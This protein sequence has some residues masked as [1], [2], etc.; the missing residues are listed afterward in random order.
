MNTKFI[1]VKDFRQNI[2]DYAKRAQKSDTR[3]IVM[4]RNKPLFEI[5]AFAEDEYLDSFVADI[6]KAEADVARG[7]YHTHEEVMKVL[8]IA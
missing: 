7:N 2:S 1:G 8:G 3:Y 4:N 5:K 6:A